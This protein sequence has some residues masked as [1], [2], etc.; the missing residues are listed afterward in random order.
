M[1][2]FWK[3]YYFIIL[4]SSFFVFDENPLI[5]GGVVQGYIVPNSDKGS[6]KLEFHTLAGS[7]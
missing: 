2:Y 7:L 6:G 1:L 4:V 5:V 3:K